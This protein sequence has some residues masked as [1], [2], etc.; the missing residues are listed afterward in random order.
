MGAHNI[1]E[2]EPEQVT[3]TSTD[4]LVHEA[5]D[6][7]TL[8][9]DISVIRLPQPV[10]FDGQYIY[11]CSGFQNCLQSVEGKILL[12]NSRQHAAQTLGSVKLINMINIPRTENNLECKHSSTC[13]W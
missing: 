11:Q 3:M 6:P 8:A 2:A 4:Y 13:N 10:T 9:N 1:R 12:I 5:W 7:N